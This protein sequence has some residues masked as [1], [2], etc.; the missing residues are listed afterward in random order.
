MLESDEAARQVIMLDSSGQ[1]DAIRQHLAACG[2]LLF[3]CGMRELLVLFV[4]SSLRT[5]PLQED[6]GDNDDELEV[7]ALAHTHTHTLTLRGVD[8]NATHRCVGHLVHT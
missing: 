3:V 6:T 7:E 1:P 2:N 4:V 5:Q 8:P